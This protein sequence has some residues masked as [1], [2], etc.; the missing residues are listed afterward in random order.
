MF[1][2][3]TNYEFE[4]KKISNFCVCAKRQLYQ[5]CQLCL[6]GNQKAILQPLLQSHIVFLLFLLPVVT[7]FPFIIVPAKATVGKGLSECNN[8]EKLSDC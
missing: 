7:K 3:T 8:D 4:N 2:L 5:E 6:H 1:L